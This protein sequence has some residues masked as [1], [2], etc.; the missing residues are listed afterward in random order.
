M[1]S[2]LLPGCCQAA[3]R[4]AKMDHLLNEGRIIA[5]DMHQIPRYDRVSGSELTR[6][7]SKDG[8]ASSSGTSP[9]SASTMT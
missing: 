6:S 2:R 1:W 5:I 4:L 3:A 8:T 9:P 7:R